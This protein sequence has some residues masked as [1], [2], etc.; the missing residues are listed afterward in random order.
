MQES[1]G[2]SRGQSKA[3]FV[4][5]LVA[6]T[7]QVTAGE[8]AYARRKM[9]HRRSSQLGAWHRRYRALEAWPGVFS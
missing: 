8:N 3:L 7:T 1:I 6:G 2:N 4:D 5:G 9:D